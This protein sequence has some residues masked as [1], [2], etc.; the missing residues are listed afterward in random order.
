MQ[1]TLIL[2]G[3][4]NNEFL[5]ES[6]SF[7]LNG[8]KVAVFVAVDDFE[9]L[10][11]YDEK[12]YYLRNYELPIKAFAWI[13]PVFEDFHPSI[14]K[15]FEGMDYDKYNMYSDLYS[16]AGGFIPIRLYREE[17]YDVVEFERY[18]E[19]KDFKRNLVMEIT[20]IGNGLKQFNYLLEGYD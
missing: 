8:R 14:I 3:C 16:D 17:F 15:S 9:E 2:T 19:S 5:F 13:V 11:D 20:E 12:L 10:Q 18:A 7:E 1:R 4:G 6:D